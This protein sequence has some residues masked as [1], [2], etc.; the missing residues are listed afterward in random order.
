MLP[1]EFMEQI[2][3][4]L[5]A[6]ATL[7]GWSEA[8]LGKK[9]LLL[10]GVDETNPPPVEAYPLIA[11]DDVEEVREP[12]R[13]DPVYDLTITVGLYDESLVE[14]SQFRML[15]GRKKAVAFK[16]AMEGVILRS[17]LVAAVE[18]IGITEPRSLFPLHYAYVLARCTVFKTSRSAMRR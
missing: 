4:E 2:G 10:V 12:G 14:E 13:K 9:C 8:N 3:R 7:Q 11:I 6:D 18:F 5:A 17:K 1:D 15:S 16:T